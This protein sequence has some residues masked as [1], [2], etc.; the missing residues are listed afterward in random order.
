MSN[1]HP[2][3]AVADQGGW[4]NKAIRERGMF[5]DFLSFP[6]DK[7]PWFVT[8]LLIAVA[9]YLSFWVR[10]EWIDFAQ[11]HYENDKGEVVYFHPEMVKDGVALPNTHDSFYFGA[12]LQKANFGMHQNNALIPSVWQNGMITYLPHLLLKAFPSLSIEELLLWLPVY[13]AGIV[14]IPLVLIGRLYGSNAWGFFAACL[15]G[16]T[17]SY[18]NRTLAGYYDTDMFSITIPAFALYFLLSASRRKS[19][20]FALAAAVT[21]Y[22]Y[23]FFYTS[24]QAI[25]GALALAYIG[26]RIG[27]V[28]LDFFFAHSRNY[29]KTISSESAIFSFQS[30]LLVAFA[31]YAETWA[32][33]LNIE[34]NPGKFWLGILILII[35]RVSFSFIRVNPIPHATQSDISCEQPDSSTRLTKKFSIPAITLPLA[36]LGMLAFTVLDGNYRA[37]IFS[38][39]DRYVSAGKGVAMQSQNKEKGYSLSYLDVFSTVREASGI[40]KAVVRNR[41]LADS[42]TCSC[43]RCLPAQDKKD[44]L[45]IPTAIFGL[46]GVGLL[47][48][49]YWEFCLTVPFLAIAYYC[50]QGAVGLRFTVHVGNVASLG[51]VFLI[52]CILGFLAKKFLQKSKV[53]ESNLLK[54]SSWGVWVVTGCIVVFLLRPNIQHAQNYHSHVVYPTKTIDVLEKLNEV[55]KPD[56]FVVTWWDYGSGCWYYGGVRTFTSPAHQT[57]D[58]YLTSEILRSRNPQRAVNLSILKT[59]TFVDIQKKQEQGLASY[60]TAVQ[61]IFKDGKPDLEFYQGI[62]HDLGQGTYPLPPQTRDIFLFLPY[63]ILRIFPTILSFS[64]RNLYYSDGQSTQ[65]NTNR[66]PPMKILRNGRREGFS[67]NFDEGFRF[68]QQGNLRV[69]GEQS[70]VV[71]YSQ[72]WRTSGTPGDSAQIVQAINTDGFKIMSK[73]DSRSTR[74]LIF[75]E[76]TKELIILSSSALNSTFTKRFLLDKFDAD[77]FSHPEFEKGVNPVRQPFITQADWVSSIPNGISLNMRG[78]YKI[79]ANL[80]KFEANIPGMKESVPFAFHRRMHDTETGKL[81]KMPSQNLTKAK[82]HLIQTNLPVF[83]GGR[84]YTVPSG[85]K[86]VE[87]VAKSNGILPQMLSYHIDVPTDVTL[88]AGDTI[89]IP[90]RGYQMSQSWFFMDQEVFDSTL[91]QGFLMEDLPARFFEKVYSTPWG[92]VYKIVN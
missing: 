12:I 41:I 56:D 83:S 25:T 62:L 51:I 90:A 29:K 80:N 69:Q 23:R 37:K 15:A 89:E 3:D 63:E 18:Y 20:S 81:I 85:G 35:F 45:I 86:T 21:L 4:L 46:L 48:L 30:I 28:V 47:I 88:P 58:N 13:I 7:A 64:S 65:N 8:I 78:G 66:E 34:N 55:A 74:A 52:L 1:K 11:A 79:D 54:W 31:G 71:T 14:C 68:D 92:K 43:P 22:L 76:K 49:R 53:G 32:Y 24:G 38:K 2:T 42:P 33:G 50:F 73:P 67:F 60:S 16:V 75:I 27:L 84:P 77:A 26:Y 19:L 17:H 57:F 87:E 40:P 10:L 61:A 6:S 5:G 44:A 70:G 36:C 9:Y 59:E 72:L 39:L 82:F 91:I